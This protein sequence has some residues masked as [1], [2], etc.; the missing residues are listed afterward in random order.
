LTLEQVAERTNFDKLRSDF[1]GH[2][3]WQ[4]ARFR[5]DFFLEPTVTNAYKEAKGAAIVQGQEG[6]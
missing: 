1:S 6:R 5:G 2:D 3:E 4:R